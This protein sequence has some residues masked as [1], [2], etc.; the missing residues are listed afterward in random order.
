MN[1]ER[2]RG[3]SQGIPLLQESVVLEG[4]VFEA[5]AALPDDSIQCVVTSPPYW[6]LR[7]YGITGQIG[8]EENMAQFIDK[9]VAV[10]GEVKRLLKDDGVL[11]LNIGD[12][13][14]SGNRGWRAP[15]KKNPARAMATRPDTPDG[16]KAKDLLGIPW[17]LAFALQQDGWFLRSDIVWHKPNA[18]P[19]SVKDRPTRAHEYIFL[20]TKSEKYNYD[21]QAICEQNGRN[22][23]SVWNVNTKPY[24]EAHFATFPLELVTPCILAGSKQNDFVLDPFFGSGTVGLACQL[25]GRRYVGIELNPA[26]IQISKN[27]L[28]IND[29]QV[30]KVPV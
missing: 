10:F 25:L 14:T 23:R 15:D 28:K 11:W 24:P 20:L 29:N 5:L 30:I 12:G 3:R 26:Y 9:I 16:L 18:M 7:D 22:K 6:G 21:H 4:D 27:R 13:Y 8:L 17:R 1:F 19:E 2:N